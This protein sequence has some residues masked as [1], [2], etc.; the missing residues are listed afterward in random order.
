MIAPLHYALAL[1][2]RLEDRTFSG[3]VSIDVALGGRSETVVLDSSG[4]TIREATIDGRRVSVAI[5]GDRLV[6]TPDQPLALPKATVRIAFEGQFDRR[7]RGIFLSG[8]CAVTQLQPTFARMLFPCF[9]D[10][11]Y[12]TTFDVRITASGAHTVVA[13]APLVRE[14][15]DGERHTFTF[16]RSAPMATH[17]V[18]LAVGPFRVV[19]LARGEVQLRI[20]SKSEDAVA[21]RVLE[22]AGD[23]LHFYSELWNVPYPW[24]KLDLV[25]IPDFPAAAI[26]TT[27]LI[28]F[29]ERDLVP[30]KTNPARQ[31]EADALLA[32]EIAH[33]WFGSLVTPSS[34]QDLWLNE[35]FATW[36]AS[37]AMAALDTGRAARDVRA[38]RGAMAA[39]SLPSSRPLR[40][41][42]HIAEDLLPL[43]DE[44]AYRK[45]AAILRMLEAWVGEEIFRT[46]VTTYL[47][48]HRG[49][50]ATTADL[51]RVLEEVSG[52]PVAA[53]AAP[54]VDRAGVPSLRFTWDGPKVRIAPRGERRQIPI[55]LKL[56]L[57]SGTVEMRRILVGPDDVELSVQE[58]VRWVFGNLD[59]AGY[60]HSSY[61]DVSAVP[62]EQLN[63][64]EG[65][66]LLSDL[67]DELWTGAAEITG[68]LHVVETINPNPGAVAIARTHL[69][70]LADLL[71][72]GARRAPFEQWISA[73]FPAESDST[74]PE[75]LPT[76][77][78]F[79]STWNEPSAISF[80]THTAIAALAAVSDRAT[81]NEIA[82]FFG[83]RPL[84][85]AA[86]TVQQT[87]ASIDSRIQFRE[88]EQLAFDAWLTRQLNPSWT[89]LHGHRERHALLNTLASG[90]YG[91]LVHRRSLGTLGVTPPE[92]MQPEVDLG[93]TIT[94]LERRLVAAFAAPAILDA[95]LL[96]LAAR[97]QEDLLA[98]AELATRLLSNPGESSIKGLS[99]ILARQTAV[100][101]RQLRGAIAFMDLFRDHHAVRVLRKHLQSSRDGRLRIGTLL[102]EVAS[103]HWT[104]EMKRALLNECASL[105]SLQKSQAA[106][107]A[108]LVNAAG[109]LQSPGT[110]P[111]S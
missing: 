111:G 88:R 34:W 109:R 70:E 97:L 87:L 60:Y 20:L 46:G 82:R 75:R 12:K 42:G 68:Y 40:A 77:E 27:S 101:E 11:A 7:G 98:S 35:G 26:E 100:F 43:Y 65:A 74:D 61:D 1:H 49:G 57:S 64:A 56:G 44:I 8:G 108:A 84:G 67:W 18:G 104:D 38:I 89:P 63:A 80:G 94:A 17:L 107:V 76:W 3:E 72:G 28:H 86:R 102:D 96:A 22:K 52:Q 31:R 53:I 15:I 110:E 79:R 23:F 47:D 90:F 103:S 41:T 21:G 51:A 39:D 106:E 4:L 95:P 62:P 50:H 99:A 9:D 30:P 6:L 29:R 73:R 37:K 19:E 93:N 85:S 78:E 92:W 32:H 58:D 71:A 45:A 2:P 10:P 24:P 81:R 16:A 54:F 66:T 14:D 13:N 59:G 25:V 91:A 33:Q 5:E 48:R 36:A 55:G 83:E 105:P 69:S